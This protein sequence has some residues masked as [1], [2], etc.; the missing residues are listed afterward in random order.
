VEMV[1]VV[2][3]AVP[4][5]LVQLDHSDCFKKKWDLKLVG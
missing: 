4:L 2:P 5:I 1:Q 3:V